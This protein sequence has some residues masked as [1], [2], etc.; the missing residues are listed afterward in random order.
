MQG[1]FLTVGIFQQSHGI[2]LYV[3]GMTA[4]QGEIADLQ[5]GPLKLVGVVAG[6]TATGQLPRLGHGFWQTVHSFQGPLQTPQ[7]SCTL[8]CM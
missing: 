7:L 2:T 4:S 5:G 1:M 3:S 8:T 6:D